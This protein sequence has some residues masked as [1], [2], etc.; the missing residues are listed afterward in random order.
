MTIPIF[1][2]PD[3]KPVYFAQGTPG[4]DALQHAISTLVALG[5]SQQEMQAQRALEAQKGATQDQAG[6][7]IAQALGQMGTQQVPGLPIAGGGAT[8]P[9]AVKNPLLTSFQDQVKTGTPGRAVL[10]AANTLSGPISSEVARIGSARAAMAEGKKTEIPELKTDEKNGQVYAVTKS[11]ARAVPVYKN[12]GSP[13]MG[14]DPNKPLKSE[15]LMEVFDTRTN[16]IVMVPK[17]QGALPPYYTKTG[18][19]TE[20]ERR[21]AKLYL[22]AAN[23]YVLARRTP[24][25]SDD[26]ITQMLKA[27]A[28]G[29]G[30]SKIL[31]W[32]AT[33]KL[34]GVTRRAIQA[35][36]TV[37][38]SGIYGYSGA[39][40]TVSEFL[41]E[42]AK[43]PTTADD[44]TTLDDKYKLIEADI[45]A[46][47][48]GGGRQL[49]LERAKG[50]KI[51]RLGEMLM[52]IQAM[53]KLDP[54][55]Q[56]LLND[57][58]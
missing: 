25:V 57:P 38:T 7:S 40:V 44:P 18:V 24:P 31:T 17:R 46:L 33:T 8:L 15:D 1:P 30:D 26:A 42:L 22:R 10:A 36:N 49:D 56:K 2:I 13:L 48:L 14:A 39:A 43:I 29:Q 21:D 12:D 50:S 47:E 23:A 51:P 20:P 9:F 3:V 37:L 16:Q 27:E 6:L 35:W 32:L 34:P 53:P 28:T 19:I 52:Q 55:E 54:Q 58:R 11:G 5:Q 4:Q 45:G 41:R